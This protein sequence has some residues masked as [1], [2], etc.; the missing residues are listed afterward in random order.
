MEESFSLKL[1]KKLSKNFHIGVFDRNINYKL[2]KN[3]KI[4]KQNKKI[5][6]LNKDFFNSK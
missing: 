3:E 1:C 4:L 5:K 6:I 2:L